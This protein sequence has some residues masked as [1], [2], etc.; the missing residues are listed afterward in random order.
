MY[1][2]GI[3]TYL[4]KGPLNKS[5]NFIFPAKY[6]HAKSLKV[7]HWLS[8]YIMY[9]DRERERE[10]ERERVSNYLHLSSMNELTAKVLAGNVQIKLSLSY[11]LVFF[12]KLRLASVR[13]WHLTV[14]FFVHPHKK[15]TTSWKMATPKKRCK[16]RKQSDA[17]HTSWCCT[18]SI[19]FY[20]NLV[21]C[22]L[23]PTWL[24]YPPPK[25]NQERHMSLGFT[26]KKKHNCLLTIQ[27]VF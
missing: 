15:I 19:S 3:Y 6:I 23:I 5:F 14:A 10:R 12:I 2:F 24:E 27:F 4:A 16:K 7:S 17:L 11:C 21:Q 18:S 8:Q 9:I 26:T 25:L 13:S 20:E 1:I 22:W